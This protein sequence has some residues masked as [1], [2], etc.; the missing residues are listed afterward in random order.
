M[1][2]QN[3]PVEKRNCRFR[4][5][6]PPWMSIFKVYTQNLCSFECRLKVARQV[7]LCLYVWTPMQEIAV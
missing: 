4:Q 3:V 1:Q 5:E 2:V 6:V 7:K